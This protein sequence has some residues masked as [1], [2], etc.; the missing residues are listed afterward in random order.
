MARHTQASMLA[1]VVLLSGCASAAL[2]YTT[3]SYYGDGPEQALTVLEYAPIRS[4]D[5]MLASMEEAVALQELGDYAASN[6]AL[7]ESTHELSTSPPGPVG[8]LVNDEAGRYRGEYFE[9]VYLHTLTVANHLALQETGAAA[10]AADRTLGAIASAPCSPC[11]YPFTRYLAAVSYEAVGDFAAAANALS[12]AVADDPGNG[13]LRDEL[14][15]VS[16]EQDPRAHAYDD[17]VLYVVLFLGRGPLKVE[18]AVPVPP[19][20][21]IAWPDYLPVAQQRVTGAGLVLDGFEYRSMQ[22]TDVYELARTSLGERK[23]TLIAKEVGKTAVQEAVA[24]TIGDEVDHGAEWLARMVFSFADRA[25]LRHWSTLPATCQIIRV[26][27]PRT[28]VT[29][30]LRYHGPG[31]EVVD[32]EIFELP[33]SWTEGPLFVTRR[34]P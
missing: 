5:R 20:H 24:Q 6:A 14:D 19:S 3:A 7:A 2:Q 1:A 29:C 11:R 28:G 27:V 26:P 21:V 18:S 25:D 32:S 22:L 12:S 8:L 30:E 16:A 17:T 15:R 33:A 31:G 10:A 23:K 34:M 9:R 4:Q 13:F